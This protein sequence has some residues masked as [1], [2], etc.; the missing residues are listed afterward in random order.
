[1]M[2]FREFLET[3]VT[4]R[5]MQEFEKFVNRLFEKLK[6]EFDFTKHFVER[7]NSDRNTPMISMKELA[8]TLKKIY[9][10]QGRPLKDKVGAEA[11]VRDIQSDLN[12]PVA[13][14][15]DEKND[16]ID[17]VAKTIMR[18]KNFSTPNTVI[19]Y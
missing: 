4:M 9:S 10:K 16:E 8:D 2:L 14:R 7:L 18:K 15:Y 19:K 1:M 13:I 11:V 3:H 6:I 5:H 17:V 12:I